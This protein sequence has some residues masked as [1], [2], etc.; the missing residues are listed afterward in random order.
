MASTVAL[1]LPE[2]AA[3][4]VASPSA[5]GQAAVGS[6][7]TCS[8][9]DRAAWRGL[10]AHS[11]DS[12]PFLD[13]EWVAAWSES[14]GP[15]DPVL[16]CGWEGS[17]LV[18]LGA[19]QSLSESWAGRRTAVV[20]SLTNVESPRF[21]FLASC[22]RPD[23]QERLWRA[24]CDA[25]R[26]DVIRVEYLPEDSPTLSAGIRIADELGWN[27]V[28]EPTLESPWRALPRPPRAWDEGLKRKF[29]ANLRNRERRLETLGEVTF[30]V[31]K[32]G[33]QRRAAL[34]T[35]YTLE[36]SG[37]KGERGTA[38]ARRMS[39][40]A[41]Y[42]G[43]EERTAQD[44]WIP[45]LS[46]AGRAVAAQLIRVR[47]R[48]LFMLKT[49]YDPDFAPYATG[50]LLTTRLI[51]HGIDNGMETLDFLGEDMTWKRDWEPRL[52][53][54]YCLLLF[55]PTARG[56]YAYWTRYG[57]REHA[58]KIPGAVRVVRWL[59]GQRGGP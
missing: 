14:F 9:A 30:T 20:Q 39:A 51:R 47:G 48:T 57:I 1:P 8:P 52:R 31:A 5:A 22:G 29:K 49:A 26:W 11:A 2:V 4:A 34:E 32:T 28:V 3:A 18:G 21:E 24:L 13:E 33:A 56:R 53:R 44:L 41:F 54:H 35:F 25:G 58:K 40:K 46:V 45:I 17:R 7:S 36:A 43:L 19:L 27:R 12:A 38:I 16:V 55:S 10:L 59:R 23:V 50:Q 15:R 6:L 42:D 37:W